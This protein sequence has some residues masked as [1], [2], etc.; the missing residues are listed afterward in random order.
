MGNGRRADIVSPSLAILVNFYGPVTATGLS[1]PFFSLNITVYCGYLILALTLYMGIW[2]IDSLLHKITGLKKGN[3][4]KELH[5]R[6]PIF[7]GVQMMMS[8]TF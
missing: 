3:H 1:F 6:K 7:I 4:S 5:L 8:W 2:E